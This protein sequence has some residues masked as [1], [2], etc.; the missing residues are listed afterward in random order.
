MHTWGAPSPCLPTHGPTAAWEAA[1]S[2]TGLESPQWRCQAT[3]MLYF[4]GVVSLSPAGLDLNG[5][6][7]QVGGVK[8]LVIVSLQGCS[9]ALIS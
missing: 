1:P 5:E 9:H 8:R 6:A 3:T 2:Q 4:R 7:V